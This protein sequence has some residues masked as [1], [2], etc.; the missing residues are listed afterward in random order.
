M[1]FEKLARQFSDCIA[2]TAA[3]FDSGAEVDSAPDAGA[4]AFDFEIRPGGV[5]VEHHV[6]RR[7]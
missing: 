5:G 6:G 1:G 3:F 2:E 4:A 7:E